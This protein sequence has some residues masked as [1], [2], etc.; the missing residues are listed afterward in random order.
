MK[1]CRISEAE[2]QIGGGLLE[3]VIQVAEGELKLVD[4]MLESRVYVWYPM[5]I[6]LELFKS[7]ISSLMQCVDGRSLKR[8]HN[9]DN[10]TTFQETNI[11]REPRSRRTNRILTISYVIPGRCCEK[12]TSLRR[13]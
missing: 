8:S 2:E 3:E 12:F 5:R 11:L 4:T 10:G 13:I 1:V 7:R 9:Q 6:E